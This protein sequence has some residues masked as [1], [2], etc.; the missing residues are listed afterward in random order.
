MK[1]SKRLFES[2]VEEIPPCRFLQNE[3]NIE[4]VDNAWRRKL[5]IFKFDENM[6][7]DQYDYDILEGD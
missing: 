4:N 5:K 2:S 3:N 7:E 6:S 1:G